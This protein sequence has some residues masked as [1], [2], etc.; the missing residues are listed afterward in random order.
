MLVEL[1]SKISEIPST[2]HLIINEHITL[3]QFL[4]PLAH[5]VR[6]VSQSKWVVAEISSISPASS[7]LYLDLIESDEHGAKI[8]HLRAIIWAYNKSKL[9]SKFEMGT[10]GE[11]LRKGLKVLF[12]LKPALSPQYGL[13]ATV[14]DIDPAFTL[15]EAAAKLI[16]LRK[17]LVDEGKYDIQREFIRP[18][19]FT[20]VAVV[21]PAF[22]AGL[23]D[24]KSH[25]DPFQNLGLCQFNYYSATFQGDKTSDEIVTALRKVYADHRLFHFDCLIIL[26]GGGSQADLAWLN[27][28]KIA[29]A[30]SKMPLPVFVAVGHERDSTI[31]DEI[32]N[33][34]FHTPSKAIAHISEMVI[35][36]AKSAL[37]AF[38]NI[39]NASLNLVNLKFQFVEQFRDRLFSAGEKCIITTTQ[40]M[41]QKSETIFSQAIQDL[42][43][44]ESDMRSQ[45]L[46]IKENAFLYVKNIM[47]QTKSNAE[48]IVGLGP[49]KTLERG[50]AIARNR[51]GNVIT[52]QKG[53][54][55]GDLVSL[56][57]SDGTVNLSV[58]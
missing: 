47:T 10:G 40:F 17:R 44:V 30:I 32:A 41:K 56:Q 53:T 22:A 36:N 45:K 20:S 33:F 5:A 14:E 46:S 15:G 13:S 31:L 37:D 48:L 23:G 34:S 11:N 24:F 52:R 35:S 19:E 27:D 21:C 2:N 1:N 7:H 4:S 58:K 38:S 55:S 28:Y 16:A 3:S 6:S 43:V 49:K 26:R 25:A 39:V 57:F 18:T 51:N 50:F 42:V 54:K 9:I 29:S 8:A 12:K